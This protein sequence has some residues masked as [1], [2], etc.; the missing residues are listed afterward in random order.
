MA[1]HRILSLIASST[2]ILCALGFEDQLVG[3]S[4]E[5]DFPASVASLPVCTEAKL[6]ARRPS[7]QIDRDVRDILERALSVYRVDPD[8]LRELQPTCIVTQTQCEVCAVSLRDVEESLRSWVGGHP[9]IVAL[10]AADLQGVFADVRRIADAL[11]SPERGAR[12]E[13]RL[14]NRMKEIETRAG[15]IGA[16]PR[17]GCV[18]WIE[19]LMASGNW[20]PQLVEMA[21][22]ENL[23]G[24]PGR[25]APDLR[26]EA[27]RD[28][29][30]DVIVVRP[31]G[32]DLERTRE[33]MPALAR[34]PG[35]ESL[36]AVRAGRV[37][38][39]DGN[40]YFNRPGP[41]LLESLEIL[42]EILHPDVFDFGH[43]SRGWQPWSGA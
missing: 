1:Q 32:F 11:G 2:E 3:R 36:R 35:W 27:L 12:L 22:G 5:C 42:A 8:A 34:Q 41:R 25:H 4:H 7:A 19:P 9:Q 26:W 14:R 24:T 23:F 31:C 20:M 13:A 21:G 18:E 40:A 43:R 39:C 33:E 10:Q 37:A 38:L 29:D 16:R 15:S 6:D 28:A 30:P 17:V